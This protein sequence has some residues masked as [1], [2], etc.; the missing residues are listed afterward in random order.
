M[1]LALAKTK[2]GDFVVDTR[3]QFI[4][5]RLL[6]EGEY[7]AEELALLTTCAKPDED[8]LVVGAHIGALA[9]PLSRHCRSLVAVEANPATFRLLEE[10]VRINERANIRCLF[11]AAS[12]SSQPIEMLCGTANSG[13]SKRT[14]LHERPDYVYDSPERVLVPAFRLDD[15]CD[16]GPFALLHMDIEGSEVFALRGATRVLSV[17]TYLSVEFISHHLTHVAGVTVDEWLAPIRA[18]GFNT[19]L[20]PGDSKLNRPH[21]AIEPEDWHEMLQSIVDAGVGIENLVFWRKRADL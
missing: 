21:I 12:D 20:L 4:G 17:T 1:T 16:E 15:V 13:G 19:M 14:P 5:R 7:S 2:H 8:I 3:D 11:A 10:N 6:A 18:A 9:I